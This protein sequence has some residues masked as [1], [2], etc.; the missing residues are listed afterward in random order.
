MGT[1]ILKIAFLSFVILVVA[2]IVSVVNDLSESKKAALASRALSPATREEPA[3]QKEAEQPVANAEIE[4]EFKANRAH[5]IKMLRE[6]MGMPGYIGAVAW[7][8]RYA[9]VKDK[10]FQ[11]LYKEALRMKAEKKGKVEAQLAKKEARLTQFQ[12]INVDA[13]SLHAGR[14]CKN[15]IR[16]QLKVP[17]TAKFPLLPDVR[18]T[19][20]NEFF[21]ITSH[22][23]AQN[24]FGAMLRYSYFCRLKYNGGG[25][26]G[27]IADDVSVN[28]Q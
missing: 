1:K 16:N 10:E 15:L 25:V 21:I 19:S 12:S 5:I 23:D 4:A 6:L 3:Q 26:S 8:E 14:Y 28:E 11:K 20:T 9:N 27:W 7:G 24:S 2:A 17:S 18:V 22:V 13:E